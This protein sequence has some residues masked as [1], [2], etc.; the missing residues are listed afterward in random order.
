MK[1]TCAALFALVAG[2][3]SAAAVQA[4]SDTPADAQALG[5]KGASVAAVKVTGHRDDTPAKLDHIMPEVAGTKITVTK[6]TTV[7]KLDQQPT[8]IDN[9]LQELFARSPGILVTEQQTPTQFNLSYR[10]LGN[11]QESEFVLVLQDGLPIST[12]WIGFPTLY[13]LPLTQGISEIQEIRGGSSLLY[14]PE[15][16]PAINFV[17]KRPVPG[18]PLTGYTEQ[19]GGSDGLYSTYNVIQGSTDKFAFRADFGDV[20]SNGQRVNAQSQVKEADLYLDYRPNAAERIGLD[21]HAYGASSGD[22]GRIGYAQFL[23]DPSSSP[24]P[25]N[26]DWVTRYSATLS[27]DLDFAGSWRLESKLWGAYEDLASRDAANS[28]DPT[29]TTLQD[30]L[31][32]SEGLDVRLR[33]RWGAG[34]AFTVGVEAYHDDAPFR[35]WTSDDVLAPRDDHSGTPIL[36]QARQSNYESVFAENVFRL[37]WRFHVVPSVRLEREEVAVDETVRPPFLSRPLLDVDAT[38]NIPLLGIGIGNDFGHQNET[39]FSVTQGWRPLRFFDVASPFSNVGPANLANNSTS[40]SYE[41]GVHGT[42][43]RGLFYDAGLFLI[44][45]DNQ[46]ETIVLSP[47]ESVN[48]NSGDTRNRGFEG[49]ISYD[50]LA[51]R[52]GGRHLTAFANLQ[53]LDARFTKSDLP[54]QVGRVPAFAPHALGKYGL[55]FRADGRYSFSVTGVSVSS[56]F[57]Q[58]SDLPAGVGTATYVPAKVPA[59]TVIDFAAD[60]NLTK[61]LRVLGGVSNIGDRRYYSRVFQNGIEPA[62]GRTAYG[63]L[64]LGF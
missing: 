14:G 34:N 31:F 15:P 49:E 54:N 4:Q 60:W 12:D 61:K 64:A 58:D 29:S 39:Y 11:P 43:V 9:N 33:D 59:Y 23:S 20:Q 3:A 62:L 1:Q 13:Y 41:G 10:G 63:G 5:M 8:V 17:S 25:D 24:T 21:V 6:K 36:R 32:R 46:I 19:V 51:G 40:V 7:T 52:L 27:Y 56:Q 28:P 18:G 42:P 47:T 35:Q 30:E 22:P 53:L 38:R 48:Q 50:F 55:T 2:L 37:P 16:A 57:F 44:D 45:F 26:E